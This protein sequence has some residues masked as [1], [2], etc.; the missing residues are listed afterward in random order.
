VYY[1]M[2]DRIKLAQ[3]CNLR[4]IASYVMREHSKQ[5]QVHQNLLTVRIATAANIKQAQECRSLSHVLF[6]MLA[7]TRLVQE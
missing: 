4:I 5:A 7:H 3:G 6:V 2:L 1:V